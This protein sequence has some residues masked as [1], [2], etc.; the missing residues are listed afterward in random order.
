MSG[1]SPEIVEKDFW[2]CWTLRQLFEL[3]DIPHLIFKGGTSL[4]KAFGII[5][6]FSEDIDL[7]LNRH[8]LG[9][10]AKND[11]ANQ[12]GSHLRNRTIDNLKGKCVAYLAA[13][14][15]PKL[16]VQMTTVLAGINWSLEAD[17]NAPDH[18]T[19]E[20]AYP[21]GIK[22]ALTPSYIKRTVR[23]EIGCRR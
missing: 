2:V 11:P 17:S 6:R 7:V 15:I 9:F 20:F 3:Q 4:S 5:K 12:T 14:F 21:P 22:A 13:Q 16:C 10:V 8:E 1:I 18:D 23:L 19:F